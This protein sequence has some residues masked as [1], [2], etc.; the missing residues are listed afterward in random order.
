[1][2]NLF[3]IITILLILASV[4][5]WLTR[6]EQ[7]GVTT[8][9]W[10]AGLSADRIEQVAAFHDWMKKT[11]RVNAKGEPLFRVRLEAADNQSTLI[12]AVSGMAGDLIDHV[13][14][15]RFA[16][17][18]VLEDITDFAR[19]NGLDPGSNYGAARD[20]LMYND[21]QYAYAC[22]LAAPALLCNVDTFRKYGMEPPPEEWTPE[23][24]ERIGLE[25]TRRAN[26]GK[27]RQEVFFSGAMPNVILPLAR[28]MGCDMFNETL[29]APQLTDPAFLK[30]LTLYHRWVDE[31]HLIPTAAEIASESS[32]QSS[33]NSDATPHLVSGRY[34]MIAT[35][36][37]VNMDLRRFKTE[38][39]N[40]SF[41]QYPEYEFKNLV[42]IS[43]NN[44]DIQGVEAQGFRQ[45]LPAVSGQ[46]RIQRAA[47]PQ[48][49][50]AAAEPPVGGE[51]PGISSPCRARKRG[52]PPH[53]RAQ[54]GENHRAAGE[55]EPLLPA[56]GG[57]D[58]LRL[59]AGFRRAL[60]GGRSSETGQ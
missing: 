7:E 43:R 23:E 42:F 25:F 39:V 41:S 8:I 50:R 30:A 60:P 58:P 44:G 6:A 19:E 29:T 37:Y 31:L 48:F 56:G 5:T 2:R 52:Q 26:A 34:A 20:L 14:V 13:P 4:V 22:N 28:S 45:D 51:Q 36:R 24:F 46:P 53:Q 55:S 35:G 32:A 16:P 9:V 59:R 33:V 1:M 11:G 49:G 38:P 21:R 3:L 10:T 17:M 12:Q 47:D 40:L 57:Q 18:G 15:K 27:P 54:M